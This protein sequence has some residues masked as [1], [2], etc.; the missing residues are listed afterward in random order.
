MRI[1][2]RWFILEVPVKHAPPPTKQLMPAAH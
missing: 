2:N 1:T